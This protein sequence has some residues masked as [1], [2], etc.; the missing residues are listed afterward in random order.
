VVGLTYWSGGGSFDGCLHWGFYGCLYGCLNWSLD[1]CLNWSL[2][3]CLN[4]SLDGCLD[5]CLDRRLYGCLDGRFDRRLDGRVN[6]IHVQPAWASTI[7]GEVPFTGCSATVRGN[8][9][10]LNAV[11]T[12]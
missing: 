2:D 3:G 5:G 10:I 12:V 9:T 11:P 1:G 7:L 6:L 4:W 8:T